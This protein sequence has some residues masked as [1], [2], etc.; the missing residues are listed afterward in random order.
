MIQ[1][2][3]MVIYNFASVKYIHLNDRWAGYKNVL[4]CITWYA[5]LRNCA[6][7][8]YRIRT[9]NYSKTKLNVWVMFDTNENR[10]LFLTRSKNL[11]KCSSQVPFSSWRSSWL[12]LHH[13]GFS[14]P[15]HMK[16]T[17]VHFLWS[18]VQKPTDMHQK[19]KSCSGGKVI[20][21]VWHNL[22]WSWEEYEKI[23]TFQPHPCTIPYLTLHLLLRFIC[24]PFAP[25]RKHIK[26]KP[27]SN[28]IL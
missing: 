2:P 25:L 27:S 20:F 13:G 18:K 16:L 22:L 4:L 21:L 11:V 5:N 7:V 9:E 28:M 19:Q 23:P 1:H 8:K 6:G 15:T 3:L 14:K 10:S 17:L 26:D 24:L 12:S